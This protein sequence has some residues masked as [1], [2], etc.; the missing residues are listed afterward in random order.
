MKFLPNTSPVAM[1]AVLSATTPSRDSEAS[2]DVAAPSL[3]GGASRSLAL[4]TCSHSQKEVSIVAFCN[5][6][7]RVL[8]NGD[9]NTH[10]NSG[11]KRMQERFYLD[12]DFLETD[13]SA[14]PSNTHDCQKLV[15][16]ARKVETSQPLVLGTRALRSD[17]TAEDYLVEMPHKQWHDDVSCGTYDIAVSVNADNDEESAF[18]CWE[19]FGNEEEPTHLE[20][21]RCPEGY[22]PPDHSLTWF[23][24]V[25]P[26]AGN[27]A[28]VP[29]DEIEDDKKV[30]YPPGWK[31]AHGDGCE[32]YASHPYHCSDHDGIDGLS[33]GE[34]C[35]ACGGGAY[36]TG[37]SHGDGTALRVS[38]DNHA[39][40]AG[41]P[42]SDKVS[43]SSMGTGR[44]EVAPSD[45]F[46]DANMNSLTVSSNNNNNNGA[47]PEEDRLSSSSMGTGREEGNRF[48]GD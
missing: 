45:R 12:K 4:R 21:P 41:R 35:I 40:A 9:D 47:R 28:I 38:Y 2:G 18:A 39:R 5:K 10:N 42:A 36:V 31:D 6:S 19:P 23:L 29:D 7:L 37:D 17:G 25:R 11:S 22:K 30:D 14:D 16:E 8:R 27:D 43:N 48:G 3:R 34:A 26:E 13:Y 32:W 1:F 24:E 46:S 15:N 33:P 20:I 44:G